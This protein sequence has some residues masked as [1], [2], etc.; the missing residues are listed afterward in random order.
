[1]AGWLFGFGLFVVI[2][3]SYWQSRSGEG[4]YRSI[5]EIQEDL[6]ICWSTIDY[7]I[8]YVNPAVSKL[9]QCQSELLL[10]HNILDYVYGEDRQW[11]E[12][13]LASLS[14]LAPKTKFQ[15]RLVLPD[16]AVRWQVWQVN[17]VSLTEIQAIGRDIT[18]QVLIE[19]ALEKFET[20]NRALLESMPDSMFIVNKE[21]IC[22]DMRCRLPYLPQQ[23]IYPSLFD[24]DCFKAIRERILKLIDITLVTQKLQTLEFSYPEGENYYE[25]RLSPSSENEV[26][27]LVRDINDRKQAEGV[28]IALRQEK[29]INELQQYFFA[30]ISHEFRTP[31][32]VMA[33]AISTLENND[34]ILNNAKLQRSITRIKTASDRILATIDNMVTIYQIKTNFF[35]PDWQTLALNNFCQE[36]IQG[37]GVS[38]HQAVNFYPDELIT[39]FVSSPR[40]LKCILEQLLNNALKYSQDEVFLRLQHQG[41]RVEITVSDQGIGIPTGD[42]CHIFEPFFRGSNVEGIHGSG[43]GLS[44][45]QKCVEVCQG[46][47][48][49]VSSP[50]GGTTFRLNFPLIPQ[51]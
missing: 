24:Y 16:R 38:G 19:E 15:C 17:L 43:L 39:N 18:D 35:V 10:S 49:V 20:R 13:K 32:N 33:I 44:L 26:M 11:V 23:V 50:T 5:V 29:E 27:I 36:I 47:I 41:D 6:I 37:L 46:R 48:D 3:Y 1:M 51:I 7:K 42:V 30:M 12:Q 8:I 22:L 25:A 4:R 40:L 45:V 14:L 2:A 34:S 9:F 31:L 21:G 28:A